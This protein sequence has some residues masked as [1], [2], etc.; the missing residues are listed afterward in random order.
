MLFLKFIGTF[1]IVL[2]LLC[3]SFHYEFPSLLTTLMMYK[4][5][6]LCKTSK[7]LYKVNFMFIFYCV[8]SKI[9]FGIIF[10]HFYFWNVFF[11][12]CLIIFV[13]SAHVQ[14]VTTTFLFVRTT[15]F[16]IKII[17]NFLFL[18]LNKSVLFNY[19]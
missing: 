8:S 13:C 3:F 17:I 12:S 4:I 11:I 1:N 5:F 14:F 2:K 7:N 19:C 10:I 16:V 6:W 9:R 18:F 15:I